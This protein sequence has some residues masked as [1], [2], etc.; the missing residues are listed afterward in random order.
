VPVAP[1]KSTWR[2]RLSDAGFVSRHLRSLSDCKAT[3]AAVDGNALGGGCELLP[4]ATS[5]SRPTEQGL[6]NEIK[7]GSFHPWL[8][9][10]VGYGEK[11]ARELILK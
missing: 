7:L 5:S 11:R 4:P 10:S 6:V 2:Q 1:S 9:L 3:I 8:I